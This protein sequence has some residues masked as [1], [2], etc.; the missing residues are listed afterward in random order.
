MG[1]IKIPILQIALCA[2][3]IKIPILQTDSLRNRITLL[4]VFKSK[5]SLEYYNN[6]KSKY[7]SVILLLNIKKKI[8]IKLIT[9][10]LLRLS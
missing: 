3:L 5:Y 2:S 10:I 1:C 8:E 7:K 4:M 9:L 6:I